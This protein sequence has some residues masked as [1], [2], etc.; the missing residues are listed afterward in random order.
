MPACSSWI[1]AGGEAAPTEPIVKFEGVGAPPPVSL[2]VA[3]S[4][5]LS[6]ELEEWLASSSFDALPAGNFDL[7]NALLD[8][9]Q[10]VTAT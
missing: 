5:V 9:L 7:R 2:T 10:D 4:R 1:D 6:V 8:D 3:E